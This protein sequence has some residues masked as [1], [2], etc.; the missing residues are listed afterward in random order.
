MADVKGSLLVTVDGMEVANIE[1][2][3]R[4][5]AIR[6]FYEMK[7]HAERCHDCFYALSDLF[8]HTFSFGNFYT[9]FLFK[10]WP[11]FHADRTLS[12]ISQNTY[13]LILSF[14]QC[15]KLPSLESEEAFQEKEKPLAHSGYSNP[16][17]YHDFVSCKKDWEEWHKRWYTAHPQDI[18]WSSASN[19]LF[20]RQDLIRDILRRE[21]LLKFCESCSRDEALLKLNEIKDDEVANVFHEQV[22]KH[23]GDRIEGYA[24]GIGEEI[25]LSNYYS[26]EP[27]LSDMERQFAKSM[28]A[29][30]SL[31]NKNGVIQFVSID[32]KHGMFEFHDENGTHIGEF[33]FDGTYNSTPEKDHSLKCIDEWRR[34]LGK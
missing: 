8:S 10:S 16:Q 25:C 6:D 4:D 3:Q 17:N 30:Y 14:S 13:Q 24:F 23:Q 32:F 9:G 5:K 28:R 26:Y 11:A 34:K 15:L 7:F 29:V 20:P 12:C 22:M 1:E 33:R 2:S 18:D 19:S 21:I 27:E 31:I